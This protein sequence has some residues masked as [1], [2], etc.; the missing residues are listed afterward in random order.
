MG[1]AQV[2]DATK[3]LRT[4]QM[5]SDVG[6]KSTRTICECMVKVLKVVGRLEELKNGRREGTSWLN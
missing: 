4:V 3:A 2:G 1:L 5:M 6:L